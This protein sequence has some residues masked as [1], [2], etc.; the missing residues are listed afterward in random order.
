[1]CSDKLKNNETINVEQWLHNHQSDLRQ[2]RKTALFG[3]SKSIVTFLAAG[4]H[5]VGNDNFETFLW[6]WVSFSELFGTF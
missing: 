2:K 3:N 4:E 1:M 6:Q 5:L